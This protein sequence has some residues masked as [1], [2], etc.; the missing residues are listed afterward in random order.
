ME[1]IITGLVI[2]TVVLII[3]FVLFYLIRRSRSTRGGTLESKLRALGVKG[4]LQ[5]GVREVAGTKWEVQIGEFEGV[6]LVFGF[7][8]IMSVSE[9]EIVVRVGRCPK[10]SQPSWSQP[11]LTKDDLSR[12]ADDQFHR[13]F[14]TASGH[15]C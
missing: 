12:E 9:S 2:F 11:I 13:R 14:Q 8:V 7:V 5:R 3:C 4:T 6:T 1:N 15:R 10:C